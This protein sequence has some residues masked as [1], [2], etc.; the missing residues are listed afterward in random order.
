MTLISVDPLN[1]VTVPTAVVIQRQYTAS[2]NQPRW[3]E[4]IPWVVIAVVALLLVDLS[5][6]KSVVSA[7]RSRT[8]SLT[9]APAFQ[10]FYCSSY[11]PN[12]F[13]R[14]EQLVDAA[15]SIAGLIFYAW[16]AI[17]Q[18][19][20]LFTEQHPPHPPNP[21]N[22]ELHDL[23]RRDG[24]PQ[25]RPQ[26]TRRPAE[27]DKTGVA[28]GLDIEVGGH[29]ENLRG[30]DAPIVRLPASYQKSSSQRC[31]RSTNLAERVPHTYPISCMTHYD[32]RHLFTLAFLLWP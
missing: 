24:G 25:M 28:R 21:V 32:L 20:F 27:Q 5:V 23:G 1:F 13:A 18:H 15:V 16:A 6:E 31:V 12:M 3:W 11:D 26:L 30:A 29:I 2:R 7:S 8:T 22:T 19:G 10:Y 14:K 9:I 17:D 4:A